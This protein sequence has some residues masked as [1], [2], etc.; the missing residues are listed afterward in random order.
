M[1]LD[2]A[3]ALVYLHAELR[4]MHSDVCARNVLLCSALRAHLS[5]FS[6]SQ[7]MATTARTA[8]G[9]STLHAGGRAWGGRGDARMGD[10]IQGLPAGCRP[11]DQNAPANLLLPPAALQLAAPELLLGE[12]C[13][14]AADVYSFGILL[15]ELT[16]QQ[17]GKTRGSRRLPHVPVECPAVSVACCPVP[18]PAW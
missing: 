13:T 6:V 15:I 7:V 5:D 1:A 11:P 2:V 16:T 9:G 17:L 8:A 4:V 12:R 18:T 3:E 10:A 14:L